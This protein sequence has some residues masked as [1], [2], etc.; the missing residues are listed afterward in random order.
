MSITLIDIFFS[1]SVALTIASALYTAF[2]SNILRS[3]FGLLFTL[4][5]VALLYLFLNAGFLAALQIMLYAGGIMVI[6]IFA[7]FFT[8]E[9]L[10][11]KISNPRKETLY[12]LLLL[13]ISMV[14]LIMIIFKTDWVE[15]NQ[16][17]GSDIRSIGQLL[18]N[19]YLI[20]FE[21]ISLLILLVLIGS[22][23]IARKAFKEAERRKLYD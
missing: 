13:M 4:L 1:M 3:A 19:E 12:S 11:T 14:T 22:V 9:I 20:A 17:I 7:I 5:G 18:L 8:R 23:S 2:S 21:M 10:T 15:N 6:V 16:L